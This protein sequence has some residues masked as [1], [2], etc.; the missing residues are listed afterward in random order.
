MAAA[1]LAIS[2]LSTLLT[3]TA[4][5]ADIGQVTNVRSTR[6][7]ASQV[8]LT[9]DRVPGADSYQVFQDQTRIVRDEGTDNWAVVG[10]LRSLTTYELTVVAVIDGVRG[11]ASDPISA[12]TTNPTLIKVK[13]TVDFVG[14]DFIVLKWP[15]R[16]AVRTYELFRNGVK[17]ATPLE[18]DAANGYRDRDRKSGTSYSYQIREVGPQGELGPLGPVV[19]GTTAGLPP[20][21]TPDAPAVANTFVDKSRAVLRIENKEDTLGTAV[22]ESYTITRD[23]GYIA[24]V[25]AT[26]YIKFTWFKDTGVA[27]GT[28]YTYGISATSF[29][30]TQGPGTLVEVTTQGTRP[31]PVPLDLRVTRT[32]PRTVV[33]HWDTMP[34][35]IYEVARKGSVIGL[36]ASGWFVDTT[37]PNATYTYTVSVPFRPFE[38]LPDVNPETITV[39]TPVGPNATDPLREEIE[40]AANVFGGF[41]PYRYANI[42]PTCDGCNFA[43]DTIVWLSGDVAVHDWNL[44][45]RHPGVGDPMEVHGFLLVSLDAGAEVTATFRDDGT[46]T[47][48]SVD[49]YGVQIDCFQLANLPPDL[50]ISEKASGLLELGTYCGYGE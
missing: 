6:Q 48:W 11:P 16:P 12:T 4:S 15:Q 34:G 17:I 39:T 45:A 2:L 8:V 47:S 49:G 23:G 18:N 26:N 31:V 44:P 20:G 14:V 24:F 13:P 5:A 3:G 28:T 7:D 33:L 9:W 32:E 25:P 29:D 38:D 10:G 35:V 42:V 30:G 36:S 40:R 27:P 22:V 37:A 19:V 21:V 46:A 1:L 50:V 43:P 41:A